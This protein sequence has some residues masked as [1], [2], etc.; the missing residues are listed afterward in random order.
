MAGRQ[1]DESDALIPELRDCLLSPEEVLA[2]ALDDA[3]VRVAEVAAI[4]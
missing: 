2:A 3:N 1:V 4:A